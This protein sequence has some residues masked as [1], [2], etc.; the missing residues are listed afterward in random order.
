MKLLF[1]SLTVGWLVAPMGAKLIT[2][3]EELEP[4]LSFMERFV[5]SYN[6]YNQKNLT[7]PWSRTIRK[8]EE[9]G[10]AVFGAFKCPGAPGSE[11]RDFDV[12]LE[13]GISYTAPRDSKTFKAGLME[14]D[15]YADSRVKNLTAFQTAQS[16]ASCLLYLGSVDL[17]IYHS[18]DFSAKWYGVTGMKESADER[19]APV[20]EMTTK[21]ELNLLLKSV[22]GLFIQMDW[23]LQNDGQELKVVFTYKKSG[24]MPG[25]GPNFKASFECYYQRKDSELK[26]EEDTVD[27]RMDGKELKQEEDTAVRPSTASGPRVAESVAGPIR[28]R[29]ARPEDQAAVSTSTSSDYAPEVL[30]S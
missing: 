7:M 9:G 11:Q 20:S 26:E 16:E 5:G 12:L 13:S 2:T 27:V 21:G 10:E 24:L 29:F 30:I 14:I 3:D 23:H 6:F 22:M 15:M 1:A 17:C 19:G 4:A 18:Q 25:T 28:T 8:I